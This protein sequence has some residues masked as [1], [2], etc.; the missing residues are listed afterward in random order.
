MFSRRVK[1]VT[2]VYRPGKDNVL[3][4]ALSRNPTGIAPVNGLEESQVAAV[5]SILSIDSVLKMS[6]VVGCSGR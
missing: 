4:D 2:I 6:Q 1:G 5:K 3:A